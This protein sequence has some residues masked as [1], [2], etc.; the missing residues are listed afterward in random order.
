MFD[1]ERI[2]FLVAEALHL[3]VFKFRDPELIGELMT[4]SFVDQDLHRL[5]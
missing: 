3:N 5:A 4:G 1:I 2:K